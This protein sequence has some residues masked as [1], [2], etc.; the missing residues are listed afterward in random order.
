MVNDLD[1]N[2]IKS[3]VSKRDYSKIGQKNIICTN[4]F[5][6]ENNLVYQLLYQIKNLKTIWNYC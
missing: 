5:C 6:Y 2:G 4:V 1:Y 3:L